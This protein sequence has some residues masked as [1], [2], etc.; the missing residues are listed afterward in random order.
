M[1]SDVDSSRIRLHAFGVKFINHADYRARALPETKGTPRTSCSPP[2]GAPRR[3]VQQSLPR[4][5]RAGHYVATFVAPELA[6]LG[7]TASFAP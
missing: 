1:Q 2:C 6:L 7:A 5:L 3:Q 4:R